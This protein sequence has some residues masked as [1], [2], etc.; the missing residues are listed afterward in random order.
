[1][2]TMG[3]EG[4]GLKAS[5]PQW[6]P[7]LCPQ[8]LPLQ[9]SAGV[10]WAPSGMASLGGIMGGFL[11]KSYSI[12]YI[13]IREDVTL[14]LLPELYYAPHQKAWFTSTGGLAFSAQN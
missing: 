6:V 12:E 5:S 1:M 4:T 9:G 13:L 3:L 7:W 11:W 8:W 2:A 10:G 14:H